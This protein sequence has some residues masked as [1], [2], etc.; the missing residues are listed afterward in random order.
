MRE[1]RI[2]VFVSFNFLRITPACAGNTI[3]P[4]LVHRLNQDHPRMCG[5]YL[6]STLGDFF[7]T[8]SPPHVREIR[9]NKA[10]RHRVMRITPACAGNT[11]VGHAHIQKH[12][13]HPRMCGKYSFSWESWH[14][15]SGS[16]PH[17][18]E[19]LL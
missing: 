9:G 7:S 18:R 12:Q 19:I 2:A 14:E 16:P 1:I 17:V 11:S 15:G 4:E 10:T 6:W 3:K 13:D 8:G 5:K